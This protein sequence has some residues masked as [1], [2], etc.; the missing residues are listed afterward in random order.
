MKSTTRG[1]AGAAS[2]RVE[3]TSE[4]LEHRHRAQSVGT[5]SPARTSSATRPRSTRRT[6]YTYAKTA[7][8]TLEP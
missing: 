8:S 4:G 3:A 1:Y 2:G 5:E 7:I 6:D